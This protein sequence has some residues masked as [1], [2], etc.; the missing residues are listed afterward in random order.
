MESILTQ[1]YTEWELILVDEAS[2]DGTA[3]ISE[4]LRQ[5]RPSR[6]SVIRNPEPLGLQR[7]ANRVL[8]MANG[9]YMMRLDAD[10]WLDEGGTSSDGQQARSYA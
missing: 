2:G 5:R 4:Q 1:L 3:S 8:G 7:L 10:D 9:K 6:I